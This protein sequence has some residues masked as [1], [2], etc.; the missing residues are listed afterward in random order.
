MVD[1]A[2]RLRRVDAAGEGA[3]HVSLGPADPFRDQG[4]DV[5]VPTVLPEHVGRVPE[6]GHGILGHRERAEP[7]R[8]ALHEA[9]MEALP[10]ADGAL[11]G[12]I[13]VNT[14]YFVEDLPPA[15][16]EL[17]RVLAPGGRGVL[18]IA[19]PE[20]MAHQAVTIGASWTGC[21]PEELANVAED[22]MRVVRR[23]KIAATLSYGS[24]S[25][26]STDERP[27]VRPPS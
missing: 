20:W 9:G 24:R 7:G 16:A 10:I 3:E 19:N 2:E 27:P 23:R 21:S 4:S 1:P 18:G 5:S 13:S 26:R 17:R 6:P 14:V 22:L 12:W 11:D 15:L 25:V 8:L